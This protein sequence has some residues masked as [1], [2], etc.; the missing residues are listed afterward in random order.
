[1]YSFNSFFVSIHHIVFRVRSQ[2]I[3]TAGRRSC[4]LRDGYKR[5][6]HVIINIRLRNIVLILKPSSSS[7]ESLCNLPPSLPH[8]CINIIYAYL[9]YSF[10]HYIYTYIYYYIITPLWTEP[11]EIS[12]TTSTF[13]SLT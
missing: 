13:F 5:V 4:L 2:T 7:S 8:K 9:V 6:D 3:P 1:M 11:D 10:R 12:G